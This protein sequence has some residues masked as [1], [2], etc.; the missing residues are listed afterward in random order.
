M[1]MESLRLV[2]QPLSMYVSGWYSVAMGLFGVVPFPI[3]RASWNRMTGSFLYFL[4]G[5][6]CTSMSVYVAVQ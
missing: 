1:R 5:Y 2:A 6:G 3:F 4:G